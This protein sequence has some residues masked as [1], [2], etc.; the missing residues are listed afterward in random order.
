MTCDVRRSSSTDLERMLRALAL[1]GGTTLILALAIAGF[2]ALTHTLAPYY[3]T[4]LRFLVAVLIVTAPY[5]ELIERRSWYLRRMPTEE[6][7]GFVP[8]GAS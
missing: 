6:R 7:L 4:T 5:A 2:G 8:G 3:G 1:A